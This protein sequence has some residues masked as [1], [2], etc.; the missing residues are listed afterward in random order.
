MLA[1]ISFAGLLVATL[2]AGAAAAQSPEPQTAP[3]LVL[4]GPPQGLPQGSAQGLPQGSFEG[5]RQDMLDLQ[6]DLDSYLSARLQSSRPP[7][8][9]LDRR[10]PRPVVSAGGDRDIDGA[11]LSGTRALDTGRWEQAIR[12]FQR[13]IEAGGSR[14]D[15]AMYW[16]AWAQNKQGNSAAALESLTRL[17]Q[18][19]PNSRWVTEARALDVEIRQAAGQPVR[20]E[21][22]ADDELKLMAL[23][24]LI[25]MEDQRAIPML[26]KILK[27]T[28][29]PKLK[30]RALFVL[31]QDGSP[32]A[33]Q[34]VT[35]IAKG[36]GNPDLQAKAINYLAVFGGTETKQTLSE[37]YKTSTSIEVKRTV[38]RASAPSRDR[39]RLLEIAKTEQAAELRAEAVQ[40]LGALGA[41]D[42]LLQLYQTDLSPEVRRR[43]VQAMFAGHNPDRL[44]RLL[45]IETDEALRRSI[46]QNLGQMGSA[47]GTE[48]LVSIYGTEKDDAVRRAIIDAFSN[49]RNV[50]VLIDLARKEMDPNLKK[51]IVER[52]SNV[53]SSEAT[54]YFLELLSK[55]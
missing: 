55:P 47:Q 21:V 23:N 13:V 15:G 9:R 8:P 28:G 6:V 18:S 5:F 31:A 30:E 40:Q 42:E 25:R 43:I 20:P 35:D 22:V 41:Q 19:Y 26:D 1:S 17:R 27:G 32:K 51:R 33:R 38:I 54:D 44:I 14:V 37:I 53:K 52:L 16:I 4:Q 7:V 36:A 10:D 46:V 39:E 48:A 24:S 12:Q 2:G 29:P 50:K 34:M 45:K 3:G 11:Y 49:E